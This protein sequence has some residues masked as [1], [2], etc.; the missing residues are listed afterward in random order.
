[1]YKFFLGNFVTNLVMLF[2]LTAMLFAMDGV[3]FTVFRETI[4]GILFGVAVCQ[5][6]FA[7]A[8]TKCWNHISYQYSIGSIVA[9]IIFLVSVAFAE[10]RP[11]KVFSDSPGPLLL[12]VCL[13]LMAWSAVR[14]GV[15]QNTSKIDR[16]LI[17]QNA[18][19]ILLFAFSP[20][21]IIHYN[22]WI[23]TS[24]FFTM[25]L[26]ILEFSGKA[27]L[28]NRNTFWAHAY[29]LNNLSSEVLKV[30][31]A[32]GAPAIILMSTVIGQHF[33]FLTSSLVDK[34]IGDFEIGFSRISLI[35][36]F[37]V[38]LMFFLQ[39]KAISN[40]IEHRLTTRTVLIFTCAALSV[41]ALLFG[42][43]LGAALF[44]T[45]LSEALSIEAAP[46]AFI[47]VFTKS[48]VWSTYFISGALLYY[49]GF[50]WVSVTLSVL[51]LVYAALPFFGFINFPSMQDACITLICLMIISSIV[52]NALITKALKEKASGDA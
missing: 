30:L 43:L 41:V 15:L 40:T 29:A 32:T 1:M 7:Q 51:P 13:C 8:L 6:G 44:F 17:F 37:L 25:A 50:N 19:K 38:S 5:I 2:A 47:L 39:N 3:E 14:A 21:A 48:V 52:S 24:S 4:A 9:A 11:V 33:E 26:L 20:L 31:R 46:M 34:Q 18:P 22:V 45:G 16:M 36:S 28:P 23:A 49:L 12:N 42:T 27:P 10:L 35:F